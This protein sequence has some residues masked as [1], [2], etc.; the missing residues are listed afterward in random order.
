MTADF[1]VLISVY[2][3]EKPEF[4]AACLDSLT[5]QTR[6]ACEVV[7]VEDGPIADSLKAVIEQFRAKL[8]IVSVA[9]PVNV[10]L[11]NALNEGLKHCTHDLVARMDTDD[12][13]LPERFERQLAHLQANP[14]VAVLGAMVEEYDLTM[15]H[16]LGPRRLPLDHEALC[17]FAK[18]R[19]PLSHPT[20][21]FRKHAVLAVGGYPSFRK[22]QDYAL[23]SLM[24]QKGYRI[25]NLPDVLLKMRAGSELMQRRGKDYLKHELAIIRFQKDIGFISG[26]A[27]VVNALLR[28][29]VRRSPAFLK[30]LLY[31]F[32][33]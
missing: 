11:A 9:L 3:S 19:S 31:K 27:F 17:A 8:P 30:Q 15:S 12:I 13:C 5:T 14:E 21:M 2:A 16:S 24:L 33:R 29:V 32:A 4:L 25:E 23:W 20:V 22:A 7:L 28:S 10:G 6:T 26:G 18:R 1:S